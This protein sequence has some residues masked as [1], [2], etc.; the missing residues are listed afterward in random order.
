MH[1]RLNHRA[2]APRAKRIGQEKERPGKG[3]SSTPRRRWTH[4][5]GAQARGGTEKGKGKG[6]GGRH[7]L[8]LGADD[9]REVLSDRAHKARQRTLTQQG[10]QGSGRSGG[11]GAGSR[12][13][14]S[15]SSSTSTA[16]GDGSSGGCV[17]ACAS[18]AVGLC[19]C[20]ADTLLLLLRALY[21]LL[22]C[23]PV[24]RQ[25]L[26]LVDAYCLPLALRVLEAAAEL[27]RKGLVVLLVRSGAA[28]A[29]GAAV[30]LCCGGL[31]CGGCCGGGAAG[32]EEDNEDEA[33]AATAAAAGAKIEKK[34]DDGFG[35]TSV[36]NLN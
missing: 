21:A 32:E 12:A 5:L 16:S 20:V 10:A 33:A 36:L 24:F 31:S 2:R 22:E 28:A 34:L 26:W 25:L 13:Q 17:Y 3:A 1:H 35:W 8:L 9:G 29:V 23:L 4:I 6:K 15:S 19:W 30:A 11:G 14:R 7:G 18:V 27:G